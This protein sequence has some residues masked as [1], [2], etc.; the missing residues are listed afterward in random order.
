M[1]S[2]C[3]KAGNLDVDLLGLLG[4][5]VYVRVGGRG[6]RR[7]SLGRREGEL[8]EESRTWVG[9]EEIWSS[10][11]CAG[12]IETKAG[13][14]RELGSGWSGGTGVNLSS[15]VSSSEVSF[16]FRSSNPGQSKLLT[17]GFSIR[18]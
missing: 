2:A 11:E 6:R 1:K 3:P 4:R 18:R 9:G 16:D 10:M 17:G 15:L 13:R 14:L 8:R 12:W 5:K 7:L